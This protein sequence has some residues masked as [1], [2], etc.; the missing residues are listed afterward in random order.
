M[1]ARGSVRRWKTTAAVTWHLG[2]AQSGLIVTIPQGR[3]FESSVPWWARW[4]V[5]PDDPRFLIAALVH[6]FLLEAGV[7]GRAQAA[8]EWLDGA[9]AGGA[10]ETRAKLCYVAVA[11][12]AVMRPDTAPL[13]AGKN[14]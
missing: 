3:E 13:A 10:P 5:D 8:A 4:I 9:L 11:I 14:T 1:F 7:Y 2:R 6:D 12:W